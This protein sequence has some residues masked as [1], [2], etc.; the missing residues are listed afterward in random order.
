MCGA[1]LPRTQGGASE[2]E[3]GVILIC[4]LPTTANTSSD[5][6]ILMPYITQR[7]SRKATLRLAPS[8]TTVVATAALAASLGSLGSALVVPPSVA[9]P[10]SFAGLADAQHV[11]SVRKTLN[12]GPN[13]HARVEHDHDVDPSSPLTIFNANHFD[14]IHHIGTNCDHIDV[15]K[16]TDLG[17]CVG[18]ELARAFVK[19]LHPHE[20]FRL[21]SATLS[22]HSAIVHAHFV[23]L[24]D[25]IPVSNGNLNVNVDLHSAKVLSYGDSSYTRHK[26]RRGPRQSRD[27]RR[28]GAD[29][30]EQK[31]QPAAPLRRV[32]SN[33]R[34]RVQRWTSE[35]VHAVESAA[36]QL[37]FGSAPLDSGPQ[38][39]SD[40]REHESDASPHGRVDIADPR[41][42]LLTFLAIQAT[43]LELLQRIESVPRRQLIDQMRVVPVARIAATVSAESL[44]ASDSHDFVIENVPEAVEEPVT[45][46][47]SWVHDDHDIKLAWK[48][49]LKTH[50]NM[51][52]AYMT[53]DGDITPGDEEALF[54]VDWV[55]DF[56][57]TGGELGIEAMASFGGARTLL[58]DLDSR[59]HL[60]SANA[61]PASSRASSHRASTTDAKL[62]AK[63]QAIDPTYKVYSWGTNAPDEGKR[64]VL[65]GAP[66]I[67]LDQEA[68]P[69]GWHTVP[70]DKHRGDGPY[71]QDTFYFETRGNNVLAQDNPDGGNSMD[72]FRANGGDEMAFEFPIHMVGP[73]FLFLLIIRH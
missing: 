68:S 22:Q 33:W 62:V 24:I 16:H 73:L 51:Y 3:S 9:A 63:M 17:R 61:M 43:N 57:P 13:L 20:D 30:S 34:N 66:G 46:T 71:N 26:G 6:S 56:R 14:A 12:W 67:K 44:H 32:G 25:G 2:A 70:K 7:S 50:D 42:G 53:A 58:R 18:R 60:A 29:G 35:A 21:V 23:Q 72:G 15:E 48:Y 47:L 64:L 39:G 10:A 4:S 28:Q 54:I 55:R 59:D 8:R 36:G 52:E 65:H 69:A 19:Q 5:Q 49:V 1:Y 38:G 11:S 31:Q 41:E 45:A 27:L 37:V 40:H